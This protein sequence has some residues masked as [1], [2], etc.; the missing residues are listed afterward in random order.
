M[1]REVRRSGLLEEIDFPRTGSGKPAIEN[2]RS[3]NLT[4]R[5]IHTRDG[6]AHSP[7]SV[8]SGHLQDTASPLFFPP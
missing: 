6:A 8:P 2:R 5:F 1:K 4:F 7:E 3:L